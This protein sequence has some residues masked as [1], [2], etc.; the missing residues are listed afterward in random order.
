MPKRTAADFAR[1]ASTD[2]PW[3]FVLTDGREL[4]PRAR[5][6]FTFDEGLAEA[7]LMMLWAR[8]SD[9]G[10]ERSWFVAA[11]LVVGA[12]SLVVAGL[13]TTAV[14]TPYLVWNLVRFDHLLPI[15]GAIGLATF[16]MVTLGVMVGRLLG[17]VAG[18]WAEAIGGVLLMAI[19]A[20]ILFEH[21]SAG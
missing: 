14:V 4:T 6:Q 13:A 2:G 3:T 20:L 15:A 18:R 16:V 19:G 1:E 7:E 9:A 11:G 12:A 21:L 5:S 8:R 17:K 10:G